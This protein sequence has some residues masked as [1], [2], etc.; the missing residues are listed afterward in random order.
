MSVCRFLHRL[1]ALQPIACSDL[2]I[3]CALAAARASH[4]SFLC[5][6]Q[7]PSTP[8]N[9]R[10]V[11]E[12]LREYSVRG[13]GRG[14]PGGFSQRPGPGAGP[15]PHAY[16]FPPAGEGDSARPGLNRHERIP[17]FGDRTGAWG[18]FLPVVPCTAFLLQPAKLACICRA[19]AGHAP[20]PREG[21]APG[22]YRSASGGE[23]RRDNGWRGD[24]RRGTL[25]GPPP[26]RPR[27]E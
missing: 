24:D 17:S 20:P 25:P 4:L 12:R 8:L 10:Q 11:N 1:V 6:L 27:F 22:P 18:L 15:R 19:C 2:P 16:G 3:P 13:R 7:A 23:L 14:G 26:A 21:D 5:T 9:A